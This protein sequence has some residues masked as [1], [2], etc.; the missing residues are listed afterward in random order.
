MLEPAPTEEGFYLTGNVE[1][2]LAQLREDKE[3]AMPF[4]RYSRSFS[5][6]NLAL[7]TFQ[8]RHHKSFHG[9][10]EVQHCSPV[11][12]ARAVFMVLWQMKGNDRILARSQLRITRA[13]SASLRGAY[14]L[15][16]H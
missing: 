8:V 14:L 7:L 4:R 3:P 9:C 1:K 5:E 15:L 11:W 16:G 10:W 12:Y 13:R 2:A 6:P